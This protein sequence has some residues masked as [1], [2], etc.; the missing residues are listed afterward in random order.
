MGLG[1]SRILFAVMPFAILALLVATI[2]QGQTALPAEREAGSVARM[3]DAAASLAAGNLDQASSDLDSVL[4]ETPNDPRALNLLGMV[5]A[6]QQRNAEAEQLFKRVIRL[7]PDTANPHVNLGLLYFQ[8]SKLDDAVSQLQEALRIDPTRTDALETLLNALRAQAHESIREGE[9][10][11]ALSLLLTA[12]KAS[13]RNPD[14]LYDFGYVALRMSLYPDSET[15]FRQ[16]LAVRADDARALYGLGRAQIGLGQFVDAS[17]TFSRYA[18]LNPDDASGHYA[19]GLTLASL[20]KFQDARPEFQRSIEILPNQT[21]SYVELGRIELTE[22]NFEAARIDFGRVLQNDPRHAEALA[23][24][25]RV[26]FG[27]KSFDK[28]VIDF[29]SS[30]LTDSSEREPHYYLGLSYARLGRKEDSEKELQIA[31]DREREDVER[32]RVVM[33]LQDSAQTSDVPVSNH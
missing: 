31:G 13:P 27:E 16:V 4:R 7:R 25:G 26:E 17:D 30:I 14:V 22:E 5:R 19:L 18:K 20:E 10:E 28:A 12:R 29:Q 24:L 9:L 2:A 1:S 23:G 8:M 21:E 15:A 11:K 3:K 6:A 32:H 33:K